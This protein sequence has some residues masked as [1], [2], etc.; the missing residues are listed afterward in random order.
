M[1]SPPHEL[2]EPRFPY[3]QHSAVEVVAESAPGPDG[4]LR[5]A[6]TVHPAGAFLDPYAGAAEPDVWTRVVYLQP[7][8]CQVTMDRLGV[9][10]HGILAT[11]EASVVV[12]RAL[13]PAGLEVDQ[14]MWR[15][16]GVLITSAFEPERCLVAV[17]TEDDPVRHGYQ[18][19]V[20][21]EE[22]VPALMPLYSS[23]VYG[24]LRWWLAENGS[25]KRT[26]KALPP[27]PGRLVM[28]YAGQDHR[29]RITGIERARWPYPPPKGTSQQWLEASEAR[30]DQMR[31]R[32]SQPDD[33]N[34]PP[35]DGPD[36]TEHR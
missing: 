15:L 18:F 33:W 5:V 30:K 16:P 10:N 36:P 24:W 7:G 20:T 27:P 26:G 19:K 22:T 1:T 2:L 13:G 6:L 23:A 8:P 31:K 25:P 17:L 9:R 28:R 29:L 32:W 21:A 14:L 35:D 3:G 11:Q 4:V 34:P 12:M